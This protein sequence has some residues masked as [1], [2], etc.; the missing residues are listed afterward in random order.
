MPK[1]RHHREEQMTE[2]KQIQDFLAEKRLAIVGVSRN[3]KDYTR[4]VFAE[5]VK[6]GYDAI[7][8]NPQ[9]TEIDGKPCLGRLIDIKP[10]VQTALFL[11]PP[12]VSD[13]MMQD[14]ADAGIKKIWFRRKLRHGE[15]S[16]NTIAFCKE[17]KVSVI[18]GLCPMMFLPE[19]ESIH[20]FHAYLLKMF[21]K[22][23]R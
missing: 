9:A 22:Y 7:P 16:S 23:P 8:I 11:V 6:R 13:D 19:A 17:H 10:P 12:Q 4:I 18:D 5:F 1:L 14:C 2:L 15:H 3:A 21:G 20:R